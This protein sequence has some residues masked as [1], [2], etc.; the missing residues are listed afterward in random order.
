MADRRRPV[1]AR[2]TLPGKH[3]RGSQR[4]IISMRLILSLATVT[5]IAISVF[6]FAWVAERNTR[7][8]LT[9][10]IEKRLLLEARNL[11]SSS[12]DVLL[13]DYPELT[14]CP[15]VKEMQE[16][17]PDLAFIIVLDHE[18]KIQ[19]HTDLQALGQ[20][21]AS[22]CTKVRPSSATMISWW[23]RCPPPTQAAAR[24]GRPWSGCASPIWKR[25]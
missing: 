9:S 10:E 19:G 14:L 24:W 4:R 22:R 21:I 17:R 5:L 12:V 1:L 16:E 13:S 20:E 6:T 11:A 15:L 2:M 23:P 3:R 25:S 7:E 18:G 8:T